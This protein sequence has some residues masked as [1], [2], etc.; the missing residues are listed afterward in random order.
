[1][2][3]YEYACKDCGH[4][5]EE[6]V[7]GLEQPT[8]P[9]CGTGRIERQMSVPAAHTASSGQ[10]ACPARETCGMSKCPGGS[11]NMAQWQ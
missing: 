5:F 3:I 1:M 10:S 6:L 7:R 11:C 9:S 2:P 8:C 4:E